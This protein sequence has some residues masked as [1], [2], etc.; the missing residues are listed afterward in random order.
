[1][2]Y[3][4]I[5]TMTNLLQQLTEKKLKL[6]KLQPLKKERLKNLED[7]LRVELTY[8]SNA[9]EG[10]TLSRIETAEVIEK[11][12]SA[13]ISGK[14]L[15]DQ[16]EA[17]N[18]VK[19][20]EFIK[21]LA[22]KRKNHTKITENDINTIHKIILTGIDDEWAGRYR[23]TEI[24][25]KGTN[26]ELPQPDKVPYIMNEFIQWLSHQKK[27]HPVRVAEDAHFKLVSIHP[28]IDGN[29]R[30]ARLLMNLI[31]IINGYPMAVIRNEERTQYLDSLERAQ[32]KEDMQSYYH[33]IEVSV[34]RSLDAYLNATQGK[35]ILPAFEEHPLLVGKSKRNAV[36][37]SE[38][39]KIGELAKETGETIHT[40]RYW[41]KEGLL[42]V[43]KYTEGG[44]QLYSPSMIKRAKEIRRLQKEERLTLAE[45]KNRFGK[46]SSGFKST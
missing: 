37:Y 24:F 27:T 38:L 9:I 39:L 33:L 45:I 2:L 32:L 42:T 35:P 18:H 41:T 26:V 29:G 44:Y 5:K 22:K 12:V 4:F 8:S 14:A 34:E 7:W 28:Y 15:K 1:M 25:I 16:L 3:T 40:L 36:T 13:V 19:A 6:D 46:N 23:E 17:V 10:N 20:I 30:T 31:L 43:T 11:G 21:S